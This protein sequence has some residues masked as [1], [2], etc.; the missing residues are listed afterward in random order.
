MATLAAVCQV[1]GVCSFVGYK[2]EWTRAAPLYPENV[3]TPYRCMITVAQ[4]KSELTPATQQL[5]GHALLSVVKPNSS[6]RFMDDSDA[7]DCLKYVADKVVTRAA[8]RQAEAE[9]A[10]EAEEAR[11]REMGAKRAAKRA[12]IASRPGP[13]V[14]W[15]DTSL[16]PH[17]Y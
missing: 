11:L 12:A 6:S 8:K 2:P 14:Y 1:N 5:Y 9:A 13:T 10:A 16:R 15:V 3:D 4:N 17:A 7:K